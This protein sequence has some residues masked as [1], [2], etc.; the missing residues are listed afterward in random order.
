MLRC[1][2][3]RVIHPRGRDQSERERGPSGSDHNA[4]LAI[5]ESADGDVAV[6]IMNPD[7]ILNFHEN[8]G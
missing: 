8:P 3:I 4:S 1:R 2:R 5:P 7:D 6:E